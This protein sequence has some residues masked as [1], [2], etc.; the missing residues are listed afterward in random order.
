MYTDVAK[1]LD[2]FVIKSPKTIVPSVT[3]QDY[4]NGYI[5]RYF[6]R[7]AN[8]K[9]ALIY[10]V[11]KDTY[12]TYSKNSFWITVYILWRITGSLE[13]TIDT[14]TNKPRVGVINANK[15][16][17]EDVS[18]KMPTLKLYIPDFILLHESRNPTVR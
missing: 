17:I 6:V 4:E 3:K 9:N 7:K 10:E 16:T 15:Y 5:Y 11:N 12:N 2:K 14:I 8:D 18:D 13:D 1:N